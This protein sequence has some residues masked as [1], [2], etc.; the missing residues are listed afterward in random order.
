[1]SAAA[2]LV[3]QTGGISALVAE[4]D[5]VSISRAAT[6][7]EIPTDLKNKHSPCAGGRLLMRLPALGLWPVDWSASAAPALTRVRASRAVQDPGS[8]I[9]YWSH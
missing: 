7:V 9:H 5:W 3:G 1:V 4:Y 6:P 8:A 2:A